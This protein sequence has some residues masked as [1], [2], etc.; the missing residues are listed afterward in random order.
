[1][2]NYLY[3]YNWLKNKPSQRVNIKSCINGKEEKKTPH[4]MRRD[5]SKAKK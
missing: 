1:M 5:C 2:R 3:V 4:N